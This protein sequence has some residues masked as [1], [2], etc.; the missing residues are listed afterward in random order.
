MITAIAARLGIRMRLTL[1]LISFAVVPILVLAGTLVLQLRGIKD[2]QFKRLAFSAEVTSEII[3]RNLFERYGDVQAFGYNSAAADRNNWSKAGTDNPLIE[4]M[5]QYMANYG[6]YKLMVM[7]SPDGK[8]LAVNSKDAAGKPLNTSSIYNQSYANSSWLKKALTG[9]FLKGRNGLTGTVVEQPM[10]HPELDKLYPGDDYAMVFAAPIKDKSGETIAVWANFAGFGLV[11]DIAKEFDLT[12]TRTGLANAE[13]TILDPKGVILV[14]YDSEILQG[15]AYSRNWD[16]IGK[17]N[18]AQ[19]GVEAASNAVQGMSGVV[20]S[21]HSRKKIEQVNG[22]FH[23]RGAYDFPGMGWSVLVRVPSGVVYAAI[24]E[25]VW[26]VSLVIIGALAVAASIGLW[27]GGSMARPIRR[28]TTA[29]TDLVSGKVEIDTTGQDRQDEI[30]SALSAASEIRD[31]IVRGL[32]T[33]GTLESMPAAVMLADTNFTITYMNRSAAA[34]FADVNDD[35]RKDLPQFDHTKLV[36][37]KI[38]LF[39][40]NPAHQHKMIAALDKPYNTSISVGGRR[41]DLAAIP[42]SD[43]TG[44]RL[45][46]AVEWRDVTQ[47]VSVQTEVTGLVRSALAGDFSQ[48]L[49]LEGKTGFM[50]DIA[51]GING[52]AETVDKATKELDAVLS[53]LAQGNL[54]REMTGTYGGQIKVLQESANSTIT[55]L[56]EITEG[57]SEASSNVNGASVEIATGAR[58]LAQ[59]TES[60]AATL[61]QTAAAM[62]EVTETVNRN[63][64]NARAANQQTLM[65]RKAAEK[66]NGIVGEAVAA[67]GDIEASAQKIS[68]IIGLIDEIAF[69]TNLLALNAS[70]EAA[71]AG[72]AGKGFAVVAQEVRALAQRS[73]NA[74]KDIKSLISA[75]NGQVKAGVQ[76]VNQAGGALTEIVS[77]VKQVTDIVAEIAAASTEQARAMQEINT[78]VGQMDEMTQRNGALVEETSAATQNL[79]SQARELTR[80]VSFFNTN[81]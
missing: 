76:L 30:G 65:A 4:A 27:F 60:Q 49:R 18:L 24:N 10:R 35:I 47:L 31:R 26:Q 64:D 43:T 36:G 41:F 67:M 20:E 7:V 75:S 12:L 58:D 81:A 21:I 44:V 1:L 29:L 22:Y 72:E 33:G 40:K 53:A 69:Q 55:K 16:V 62:H 19:S 38:D 74:S 23:S 39:H 63:A 70:V 48:R 56:R 54:K 77:T 34:M 61:E 57:I 71:R 37:S 6:L 45:G 9:E 52:M 17:L 73:A 25:M 13:L 5:N 2:E 3:D 42:V 28:V 80:L 15:K 14:D 68:D 66:G 8:V 11:E 50:H 32:E 59:R 78:A 51:A 46:T 79:A